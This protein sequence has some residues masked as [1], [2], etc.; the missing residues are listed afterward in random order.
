MTIYKKK[1][2]HTL[3]HRIDE[4][5]TFIQMVAGPQQVGK[6]T[7]I[8][9]V[10]APTDIPHMLYN[11]D[12]VN[13]TD[14]DWISRFWEN[15]RAM[16]AIHNAQEFLLVIDEIQKIHNW[17]EFVKREWTPHSHRGKKWAAGNEQRVAYIQS[18]VST[19]LTDKTETTSICCLHSIS[20]FTPSA[21]W[22]LA[23]AASAWK[24]SFA[25][26]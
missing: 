21:L 12:T 23:Q 10:L 22:L 11:A 13:S 18:V 6:S 7:L 3:L 20:C 15:A 9:Q 4:Q 2:F 17:S 26:T 24:I 14:G 5:R 8:S 1:E 25:L 16:K 19:K